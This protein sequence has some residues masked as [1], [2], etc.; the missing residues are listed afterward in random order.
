LPSMIVGLL[1]MGP[2]AMIAEKKGKFKAILLLGIGVL[3]ISYFIIGYSSTYMV[4]SVGVVIFFIGFN[5]QEPILQSL[6]TKFAKVHQRGEVL[7]VFNSFG[8]F[9]TFIGGAIGGVML[10][11]TSLANISYGIIVICAFWALM[12]VKLENPAL[13]KVAYIHLDDT[14]HT[15]HQ[16]LHSIE[17]CKEW[18]I[19]DTENVVVVKYDETVIDEDKIRQLLL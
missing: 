4:F 1:S 12:V 15:K 17:G 11:L 5:L 13:T 14:D 16:D 9:G 10:D 3:S 6:T 2:A 8:Y 7:G 19:N 18:Y